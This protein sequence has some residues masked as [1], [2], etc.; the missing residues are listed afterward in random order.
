VSAQKVYIRSTKN[1][2]L[3][4]EV[5]NFNPATKTAKIQGRYGKTFELCPFNKERLAKDDYELITENTDGK[6]TGI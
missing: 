5:L 4:F 2:A 6:P 3:K 1:P